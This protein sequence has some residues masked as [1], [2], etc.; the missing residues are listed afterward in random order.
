ML[1][2]FPPVQLAQ[3]G[4]AAASSN[5]WPDAASPRPAEVPLPTAAQAFERASAAL[6]AREAELREA[7]RQLAIANVSSEEGWAEVRR[8]E[9]HNAG[10]RQRQK[11]QG[12]KDDAREA[13][14]RELS[15]IL[16][17]CEDKLSLAKAL[18]RSLLGR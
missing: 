7:Q 6:R 3:G 1:P 12:A 5:A 14:L 15:R 13:E 17:E 10:W 8:L 9:F 16:A 11:E 4:T 2:Y 18:L